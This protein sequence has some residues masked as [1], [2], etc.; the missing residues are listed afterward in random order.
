MELQF[1]ILILGIRCRLVAIL[2]LWVLCPW[3]WGPLTFPRIVVNPRN[4]LD[5][6][7]RRKFLAP[8]DQLT[9]LFQTQPVSILLILI[10]FLT[11]CVFLFLCTHFFSRLP[12]PVSLNPFA[13]GLLSIFSCVICNDKQY[14][15]CLCI[16]PVQTKLNCGILKNRTRI[17][18]KVTLHLCYKNQ[19]FNAV[20]LVKLSHYRPEQALRLPGGWGS[21][22]F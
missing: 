6:T 22:N 16:K 2:T 19:K 3:G 14:R 11:L 9:S 20:K 17:A 5:I 15:G 10:L 7:A 12:A 4:G 1:L 18:K 8:A 13:K 21:Q